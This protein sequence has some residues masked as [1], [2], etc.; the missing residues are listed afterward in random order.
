MGHSRIRRVRR[1]VATGVR[2]NHQER[3]PHWVALLVAFVLLT[4]ALAGCGSSTSALTGGSAVATGGDVTSIPSD[5]YL[6]KVRAACRR[7]VAETGELAARLPKF[8]AEAPNGTAAITEGVVRQGVRIIEAEARR[9]RAAGPE[10]TSAPL[11][12]FVGL[13]DPI[14]ELGRQRLASGEAEDATL[15]HRLEVLVTALSAEQA[16]AA[17]AAGLK[18]CSTDFTQALGGAG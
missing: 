8:F 18:P 6:G 14:V 15:S 5:A 7:A 2:C 16:E 13:F 4:G 10:P 1:P 9:V 3:R 17:G 11:A 12:V